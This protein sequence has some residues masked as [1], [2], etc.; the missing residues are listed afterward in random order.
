[1]TNREKFLALTELDVKALRA[2][3]NDRFIEWVTHVG[4]HWSSIFQRFAWRNG[5]LEDMWFKDKGKLLKWLDK[6][7]DYGAILNPCSICGS[8]PILDCN[9]QKVWQVKC[10]ACGKSSVRCYTKDEAVA[11]WNRQNEIN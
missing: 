3:N 6:E 9:S 2:M 1:M 7:A 4:F 5:Y 11:A 8:L 10:S